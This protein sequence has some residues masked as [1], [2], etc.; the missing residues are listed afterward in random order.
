M[1]INSA[2][3]RIIKRIFPEIHSHVHLPQWGK[4]VSTPGAISGGQ[5]TD[6]EPLY[7]VDIQLLDAQG[8]INNE[9]PVFQ[10]IPLPATACGDNRGV[11]GFPKKDTLVELGFI[12]GLPS[13]PFI[14]SIIVE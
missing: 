13:K 8:Q 7:C 2:I 10:K 14:R 9:F 3:K 11:F 1:K 12:M 4:I 5:S 6:N